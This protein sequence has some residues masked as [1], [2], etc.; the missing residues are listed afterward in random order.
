VIDAGAGKPTVN[1]LGLVAVILLTSTVT[2][3]LV[4]SVGT[5]VVRDVLLAAVTVAVVPLK[6]TAFADGVELN[7]VPLIVTPIPGGAR[8]GVML[9]IVG[10]GASRN[11]PLLV[12]VGPPCTR[13]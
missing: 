4:A 8:F 10:V 7:P 11:V 12:T 6:F 3:P 13:S 1:A 2:G 5:D 9:V